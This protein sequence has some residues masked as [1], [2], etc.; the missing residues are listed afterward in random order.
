MLLVGGARQAAAQDSS[1]ELM[2]VMD[3]SGSMAGP[4]GDGGTKIGAAKKAITGMVDSAPAGARVGLR[5]YGANRDKNDPAACHDS[6]RVV[7]VARV[8]KQRITAAA[9]GMRPRGQTPIAYSLR[10][11]AD[12]FSGT[13]PRT[14]MLVSDGIET[15]DPDPCA[16]ARKLRGAGVDLRIDV[17]GFR[18][19]DKA[20]NQ[21]RCVARAGHGTYHDVDD[22]PALSD[23]LS[24]NSVRALRHYRF[25][26]TPVNGGSDP[27]GAPVVRP[28]QYL[29]TLP[30]STSKQNRNAKFYTVD[31]KP[32]ETV[33]VSA[34]V[35][36]PKADRDGRSSVIATSFAT[37]ALEDCD[38][39]SGDRVDD[40]GDTGPVT[41]TAQL[42]DD[43]VRDSCNAGGRFHFGVTW[44]SDGA[45]GKGGVP[46]EITVLTEP[47]VTNASSLPE[48][49]D[50]LSSEATLPKTRTPAKV[51]GGANF[52]D[53]S[54]IT[55][56]TY[57][58]TIRPGETLFYRVKLG[59]GQR[60][61]Y[62]ADFPRLSGPQADAVADA[63]PEVSVI[64]ASPLRTEAAATTVKH[65]TTFRDGRDSY[66]G[67]PTTLWF[68][69]PQV[70]YRNREDSGIDKTTS[71][72]LA[73]YYYVEVH[74]AA[75]PGG[76]RV[77][78]PFR[79]TADV[80]GE[81]GGVPEYASSAD[82]DPVS[83][84][85]RGTR[86]GRGGGGRPSAEPT[87]TSA[88]SPLTSPIIWAGL[89]A[90]LL[91]GGGGTVLALALRRR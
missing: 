7:D 19:D 39:N 74:M 69:T 3:S 88:S 67:S 6:R 33:H 43:D 40:A 70:L 51:A 29:D 50:S 61:A 41:A 11:A 22:G 64:S 82:G 1:G 86:P 24:R 23:T 47:K 34:T 81:V 62:R 26:G 68:A 78:V 45:A 83:Q 91:V 80:Q 31:R 85:D 57:A 9:R 77:E 30:A 54:T 46:V 15:C 44:G 76:T 55:P 12:D 36:P 35:L 72:S 84:Q 90:L 20:R 37:S 89:G 10:K 48:E 71:A 32:G 49:D 66:D 73:G 58:D 60:L 21:L 13:A 56:G 14:I 59:W 4:D 28:G 75:M 18:V 17:V 38:S 65:S 8:D 42:G 27:R 25:A 5:V 53:A 79:L 52:I 2:I 87:G 16:V 63:R